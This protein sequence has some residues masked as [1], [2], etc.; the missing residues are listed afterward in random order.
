MRY[1]LMAAIAAGATLFAF[2]A[3]A[4]DFTT[5]KLIAFDHASRVVTLDDGQSFQ[6]IPGFHPHVRVGERVI[7]DWRSNL[8]GDN[9]ADYVGPAPHGHWPMIG[10]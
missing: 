1:H 3:Q 9:T 2:A 5:G 6:L 7:V 8:Y 4:E 10:Q